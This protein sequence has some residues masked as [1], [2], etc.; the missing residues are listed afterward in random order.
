MLS[1]LAQTMS[2]YSYTTSNST[3]NGVA[4]GMIVVMVL[5]SLGIFAVYAV[6]LWKIFEKAGRP[7]WQGIVP[8]YNNWVLA[9]I[10]GKPGW[11]GIVGLAGVI[12]LL[13]I[14]AGLAAFV[15]MILISIELVKCFGKDPSYAAFLVLLPII[16]FPMLA[17][18]DAKYT[19]PVATGSGPLPPTP[20]PTPTPTA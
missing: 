2:D 16:G 14:F 5:I 12:P 13:G 9:E 11:W 20:T 15:L 10:A 19:A 4:A 1:H 18:S 3:G 6:S 8:I 17:F 7:G